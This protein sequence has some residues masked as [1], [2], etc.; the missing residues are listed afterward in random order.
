MRIAVFDLTDCE[1]C[2][3]IL[4]SLQDELMEFATQHEL[5]NF[6]FI[7]DYGDEGPFDL[8]FIEGMVSK[9]E[10][11]QKIQY[12]RK[13]SKILVTIGT[14]A[15]T[16]GINAILSSPEDREAAKN[17]I[18]N[19]LYK[20]KSKKIR[21]VADYVKVDFAIRG[22]PPNKEQIKRFLVKFFKGKIPVQEQE[23]VCSQCPRGPFK[24]GQCLVSGNKKCLGAFTYAGCG[25]ICVEQGLYCWGCWGIKP[26]ITE[27]II[28]ETLPF[29]PEKELKNLIKSFNAN[30]N[31]T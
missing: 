16:G 22:C 10:D 5:V 17:K 26:G 19:P 7:S 1:G 14:C 25:G 31:N 3:V 15:G 6:R 28:K 4:L 13:A 12:L 20:L 9:D 30:I 23:S 18:Y 24:S 29:L 27:E 2:E 8:T 21:A 11:I